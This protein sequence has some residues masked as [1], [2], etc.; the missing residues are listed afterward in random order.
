M[1]QHLTN[2]N[3]NDVVRTH[4]QELLDNFDISLSSDMH[5]LPDIYWLP[6]LHKTPTKSR[7]IIASKKCSV[8]QLSKDITSIFKL[9]YNQIERYNQ[10]TSFYSN[11]NTFWVTQNS[12]PILNAV[13]KANC[14]KNAKTVSSFDFS[15][16]YTNI[17]HSKLYVE[18]SSIINFIFKGGSNKCISINSFGTAPWLNRY[19]SSASKYDLHNFESTEVP[20]G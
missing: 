2:V 10:K 17:P 7:F 19:N 15:T 6:K 12:F 11:I 3:E 13:E 16:L 5:S 18:L 20:A 14:K 9:A 4:E 8:K 1:Y